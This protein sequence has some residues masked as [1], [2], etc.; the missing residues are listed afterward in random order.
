MQQA[1]LMCFLL[2]QTIQFLTDIMASLKKNSVGD[3]KKQQGKPQMAF[4]NFLL[5]LLK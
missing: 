4:Y 1:D 5:A 3:I 2:K